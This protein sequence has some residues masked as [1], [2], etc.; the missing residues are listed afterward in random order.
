MASRKAA[1]KKPPTLYVKNPEARRL[2]EQVSI[3][4][5]KV[6]VLCARI[7]E[8]PVVDARA[9]EQILGYNDPGT[10]D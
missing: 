7:G 1:G 5:A 10:Q 9:P 2:A 6:D 3:D 4:R 8:L